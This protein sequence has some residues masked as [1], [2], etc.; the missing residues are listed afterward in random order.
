MS[1]DQTGPAGGLL[2][3]IQEQFSLDCRGVHG[4][5]HWARVR[6]NG[7][8]LAALTTAKPKVVELFAL[9]HDSRRF[10]NGYDPQHG[11]RAALYA[12]SLAGSAF[13]LEA[14]DL[15]LLADA[16][17]GHSD[18]LMSGDITVLTCWDADR[19]DLGRVGVKPRPE[20]LCTLAARDPSFIEWAYQRSIART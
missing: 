14:V 4:A 5:S 7:L 9:L 17:H 15:D 19:L 12:R 18:G 10:T 13:Q 1:L 16:C 11:T 8:R 6:D 3:I 20:R 2:R